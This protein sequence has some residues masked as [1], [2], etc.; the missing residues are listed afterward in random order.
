MEKLL[1]I[2]TD[3]RP[4]IDFES[5][6]KLFDD[7]VLDSFDIATVVQDINMAFDIEIGVIDLT[8]ENFNTVEGMMAMIERLQNEE[9]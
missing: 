8:P 9:D 5:E 1:E 6:K 4:D 7:K 2:L 3:F